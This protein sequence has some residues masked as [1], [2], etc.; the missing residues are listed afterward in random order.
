MATA[1]YTQ[2]EYFSDPLRHSEDAIFK[3][4]AFLDLLG[5]HRS[6]LN[7]RTYADV[8]CG[9]G[10]ATIA[11]VEGL[12]SR[13]VALTEATGYDVSPHVKA[14]SHNSV[15]FVHGTFGSQNE[16]VDLVTMF[17]V[18]E[19]VP[20][21]IDF[22]AEIAAHTKILGL[23]IPLDNSVNVAVRNAYRGKLKDPGHLIALDTASA[24]N[25]LACAGL[26]T[27]DYEYTFAFKAP[28]GHQ[29]FKQQFV[30]PI[31]WALSLISPWM[32]AKTLGGA[33]LMALAITPLGMK[34]GLSC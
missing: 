13:G 3:A 22:L 17:D 18:F 24:L 7:I 20:G 14:L 21:P 8:G 2:G 25:L 33:S 32:L 19:H 28:S 29:T 1:V 34:A 6:L 9:S 10:T 23:H 16:S 12:R 27:I 4:T 26:Q 15:R 11:V 5:S 31:R 30:Y